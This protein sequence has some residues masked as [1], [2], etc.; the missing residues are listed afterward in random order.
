[1]FRGREALKKKKIDF[2]NLINECSEYMESGNYHVE[3]T[4]GKLALRRG[5]FNWRVLKN[6]YFWLIH[7]TYKVASEGNVINCNL[8]LSSPFHN[9]KLI[10]EKTRTAYT[11]YS[12][13]FYPKA[14]MFY[15]TM[16][17][18][19]STPI[20]ALD[21]EHHML[22]EKYLLTAQIQDQKECFLSLFKSYMDYC[23]NI[24]WTKTMN[25]AQVKEKFQE[26]DLSPKV[27]EYVDCLEEKIGD[28]QVDY[29]VIICHNDFHIKNVLTE[30]NKKFCLIDYELCGE[31]VFFLRSL[32]LYF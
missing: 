8:A 27:R 14:E 31:N 21:R 25:V 9:Y 11:H 26:A 13:D 3:T 16:A 17:K 24:T 23:S 10:E 7:G 28:D 19:F 29:P 20:I 32:W 15:D 2:I 4:M 30:D 6:W 5:K 18:Y 1:M 12:D 22:V